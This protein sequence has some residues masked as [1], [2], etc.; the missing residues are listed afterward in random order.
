[1]ATTTEIQAFVGSG[2]F[3]QPNCRPP[4]QERCTEH[5]IISSLEAV[6]SGGHAG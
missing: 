2:V 3:S 6:S 5:W 1:V 4:L